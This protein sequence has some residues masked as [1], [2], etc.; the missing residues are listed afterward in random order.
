MTSTHRPAFRPPQDGT[1]QIL[2]PGARPCSDR[3]DAPT[4]RDP[5]C[6]RV[7]AFLDRGTFTL[8]AASPAS[9]Y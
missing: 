9:G 6:S 5:D 1:E 7:L 4:R 8:E 3:L 2:R